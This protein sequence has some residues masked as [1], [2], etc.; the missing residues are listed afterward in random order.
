MGADFT[1]TLL[2]V[3][4][5][6][7]ERKQ[8]LVGMAKTV[9]VQSCLEDYF[10]ERSDEE[11]IGFIEDCLGQYKDFSRR[12]DVGVLE[13]GIAYYITGGMSWGDSPTDSFDPMNALDIAFGHI[14]EKWA[15]EEV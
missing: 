8:E 14:F 13:K 11:W 3:C 2:P 1:F 9:E 6:T 12:R 5:L 15:Q 7:E 4:K 10:P